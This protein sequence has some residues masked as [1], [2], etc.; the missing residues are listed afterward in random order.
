[1]VISSAVDRLRIDADPDPN[2]LV[3]TDPETYPDP[4]WHQH[5]ADPRADPTPSFTLVGIS[6]IFLSRHFYLSNLCKRGHNF[7][8]FG[9]HMDSTGIKILWKKYSHNFSYARH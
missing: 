7:K 5:D 9:Q 3:D 2:F 4:D 8:N 6:D 1:M